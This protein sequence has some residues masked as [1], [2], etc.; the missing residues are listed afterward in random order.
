MSTGIQPVELEVH[1]E[2]LLSQVVPLAPR[3]IEVAGGF[4]ALHGAVLAEDV[5]S[6]HPLPLWDNSAMDG[7]AVRSV[8]TAAAPVALDLATSCVGA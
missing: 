6:T 4:A 5:C 1:R 7:Y 3:Q 8:D 2:R